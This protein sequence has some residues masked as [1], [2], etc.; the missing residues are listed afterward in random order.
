MSPYNPT[1]HHRHSIRLKGY[2]Y[3][4]EGLYLVTICMQTRECLFGTMHVGTLKA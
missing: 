2:D 3:A 1:I 4:S